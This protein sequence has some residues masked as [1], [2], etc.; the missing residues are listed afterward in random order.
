MLDV[1]TVYLLDTYKRPL[2]TLTKRLAALWLMQIV[3]M[4][5][6]GEE[7]VHYWVVVGVPMV[8]LVLFAASA[9]RLVKRQ[10]MAFMTPLPIFLA[11]SAAVF[12]FGSLY[13][14]FS[15]ETERRVSS[16]IFSSDVETYAKV[17]LLNTT[18]LL[19]TL[20]GLLIMLDQI[21]ARRAVVLG[22]MVGHQS[23]TQ[24]PTLV[25]SQAFTTR[26]L[27][28]AG[29]VALLFGFAMRFASYVLSIPMEFP[30]F[31]SM[32]NHT[33][34]ASV[35]FFSIAG[36]R[37]GGHA[38][39][40]AALVAAVEW[41]NGLMVGIRTQALFPLTLLVVGYYIGS[42]SVKGLITGT[43]FLAI[44]LVFITPIIGE[45]RK[46]TWS[47]GYQGTAA[48]ALSEAYE[49]QAR[50]VSDHDSPGY[51][52]WIRLDYSPWEAA[53]MD[54]YDSGAKGNT[55]RYI[56]WTFVP[57]FLAPD[58]PRFEIGTDIGYAVQG[59]SQ[60]SSFSGTVYG[61]MYWN[62]GWL[63]VVISS[64]IYGFLLGA[65]TWGSSWLFLQSTL[66]A[67]LIGISGVMYGLVPDDTF[68]VA[69][70]GQA[71]IFLMLV[72]VYYKTRWLWL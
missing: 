48:N 55:Y 51:A 29:Y 33:G 49:G 21:T 26:K 12:G 19:L 69:V 39:I 43:I 22:S 36:G 23:S 72:A 67:I 5:L 3:L 9:Y 42:R 45:I 35:L 60:D 64:L 2:R 10:S 16:S 24:T 52:V 32:L 1:T 70:I 37:V 58:K 14:W 8:L 7:G 54:L 40:L 65:V 30:G 20:V 13:Q 66:P 61:E 41:V 56:L 47:G 25:L 28:Q 63:A 71:V 15:P 62:G 68:S 34:T 46:L 57:R 27:I 6:S 11:W 4:L 44:C 50:K 59:I 38:L 31:L 17:A 18:G 53:M